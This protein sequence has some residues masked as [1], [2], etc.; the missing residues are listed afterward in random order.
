[1]LSDLSVEAAKVVFEHRWSFIPDSRVSEKMTVKFCFAMAR[2][3]VVNMGTSSK[4][5]S[6]NLSNGNFEIVPKVT[7]NRSNGFVN[8]FD[9][10]NE[11]RVIIAMLFYSKIICL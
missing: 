2:P 7:R 6:G 5:G 11:R 10:F 4:R 3:R 8:T 9:V 1:M